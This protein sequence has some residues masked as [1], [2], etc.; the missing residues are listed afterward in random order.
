MVTQPCG[1]I[2][3]DAS[4]G[5]CSRWVRSGSPILQRYG[6]RIA[7]L[8]SSWLPSRTGLPT[9]ELITEVRLLKETGELISG[10]EVYRQIMRRIWWMFP[11]YLLSRVPGLREIFDWTYRTVARH[12]HTISR[13]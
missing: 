9:A 6:F 5:L 1:I 11:G 3:Y 2:L 12:R 7:P 8:Q 4:C 13:G 10:A